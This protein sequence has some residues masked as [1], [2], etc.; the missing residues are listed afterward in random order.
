MSISMSI[1]NH[2]PLF[3][4]L[5]AIILTMSGLIAA[6]AH[7]ILSEISKKRRNSIDRL[8]DNTKLNTDPRGKA[9]FKRALGLLIKKEYVRRSTFRQA[10]TIFMQIAG[11]TPDAVDKAYCLGWAGR[12]YE[13]YG[14]IAI[15]ATCYTAAAAIA[16]SDTYASERLGD[17]FWEADVEESLQRYEQVLE[18]DPLS[19]RAYYK[20][21]K[22][23]SGRGEPEKAIERFRS[24]IKVHNGYV[25]PM[26]EVAMEYAKIGDKANMLKFYHLAMANDVFEFERLQESLEAELNGGGETSGVSGVPK[27]EENYG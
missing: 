13:D 6:F 21:G 19:P 3:I 24:A 22:L 2:L 10:A 4:V 25:A 20:L 27:L 9:R 26:A 17:F 7:S 16:P 23:H 12:C 14:N 5:S 1:S 15:A 18:Y 8:Y 11:K